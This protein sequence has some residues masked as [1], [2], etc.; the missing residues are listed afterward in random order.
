MTLGGIYSLSS[1]FQW[2]GSFLMVLLVFIRFAHRPM[3][4]SIIGAY[5]IVSGLLQ[6]LQ[7]KANS[8]HIHSNAIGNIYVLCEV[9]LLLGLYFITFHNKI[10]RLAVGIVFVLY[11]L[12][13]VAI[14]ADQVTF[15]SGSIRTGRDVIMIICAIGFFS[16]LLKELPQENVLRIP[17]F[18]IN[19][20]ILFFF[21]S[22]FILSL[23]INYIIE[24]MR[25]DFTAY[26]AF[27]NFLRFL[28]CVVI[29]IGIW[30][31]RKHSV[32]T[33]VA[34]NS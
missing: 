18:W 28:F 14:L 25:D 23:S 7:F 15:H 29:C 8:L 17:M 22:T 26:W 5:G 3:E 33:V 16:K 12:V 10:L 1:H 9:G 4:I 21:S 19:S 6:L 31:A 24:M 2:L 13:Y 30:Q 20:S 11:L 27:R 32:K 34:G